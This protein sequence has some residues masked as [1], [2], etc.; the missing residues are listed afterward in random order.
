MDVSLPLYTAYLGAFLI[1][2]QTILAL[3]VGAYRGRNR[4]A[5]G[6][7]DDLVLERSVRRHAN[8]TEYAPIFLIVLGLFELIAGQT[9]VI[10]WLGVLFAIGRIAHVIGFASSA[11]SHLVDPKGARRIF[12]IARMF[13]TAMTLLTSL[14]LPLFL[15]WHLST[16][17]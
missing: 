8:M 5:L 2:L 13:G 6:T 9:S 7:A 16:L 10:F 4:K 12:I 15:V 1:A 11:G 17:P 14:A 3:M